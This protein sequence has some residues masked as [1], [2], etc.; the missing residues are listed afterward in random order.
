[1]PR[2]GLVIKEPRLSRHRLFM[3]RKKMG[4][5]RNHFVI[6][7]LDENNTVGDCMQCSRVS[8]IHWTWKTMRQLLQV[9]VQQPL[10][11]LGSFCCFILT[12]TSYYTSYKTNI[13]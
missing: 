8:F 4:R 11:G 13:M 12:I 10:S 6:V 5:Q 9:P 3:V 7:I 2:H 1:M